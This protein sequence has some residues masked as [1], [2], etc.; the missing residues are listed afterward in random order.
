MSYQTIIRDFYPKMSK[1]FTRLADFMLDSYIETALMTATELAHAVD[2]DAATVVRFA[3]TL[4]YSGFPEMQREIR[5]RVR[6]DLLLQPQEAEVPDSV[7]G[8]VNLAFDDLDKAM[9]QARKLLDSGPVAQLVERI[10]KAGR[11]VI[12]AEGLVRSAGFS[13]ARVL[14]QGGFN[15]S[16]AQP[17]ASGLSRAVNLAG[18]EDLVIA[19][20]AVGETPFIA[21]ALAEAKA[22]NVSTAAIVGAASLPSA[23]SAG[24]VLAAQA[25]AS[26]EL[27]IILMDVIVYALAQ[28]LRRHLNDRFVGN[29]DAIERISG[30]IQGEES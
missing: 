1:S 15:V 6:R 23:R 4:G 27:G 17:G 28:T 26:V 14:E 2:V 12:L 11:I 16:V 29:Q 19:V 18:M 25:Q 7:P 24:I 30:R 5:Q 22:K 8:M 9:Q 20:E 10:E 3:Q 13:L 21:R